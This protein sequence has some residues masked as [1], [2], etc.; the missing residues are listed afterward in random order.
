MHAIKTNTLKHPS[1]L[2]N[3]VPSQATEG[4]TVGDAISR[5]PSVIVISLALRC[6]SLEHHLWRLRLHV[7]ACFWDA[8]F[9]GTRYQ[10]LQTKVY[11]K[12]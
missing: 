6:V 12:L 11:I 1:R 5:Q 9:E 7:V 4:Q 3:D 2:R 10:W 8:K